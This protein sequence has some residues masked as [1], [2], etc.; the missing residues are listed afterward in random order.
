ML[1][2]GLTEPLSGKLESEPAERC[3]A[4]MVA[5]AAAAALRLSTEM[6]S[7]CSA[8]EVEA[9]ASA[10]ASFSAVNRTNRSIIHH[11]RINPTNTNPPPIN[12]INSASFIGHALLYR[13]IA[14]LAGRILNL[15]ILDD[16]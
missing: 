5:T 10:G 15:L 13:G 9:C 12:V 14:M 2:Q 1:D 3:M 8:S 16:G 4:N 7:D 11:S 6:F